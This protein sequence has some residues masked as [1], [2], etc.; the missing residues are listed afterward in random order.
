M[1]ELNKIS[2]T[3][4]TAPDKPTLPVGGAFGGPSPDGNSVIAH[5]YIEHGTIPTVITHAVAKDGAVDLTK[6][7]PIQRSHLTRQVVGTIVL[8]PEAAQALGTFLVNSAH[9]A[10]GSRTPHQKPSGK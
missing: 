5:L 8:S 10:A 4:E 1:T 3:Y 6:G 7:D 9:A 2:I